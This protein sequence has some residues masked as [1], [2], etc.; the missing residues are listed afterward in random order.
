MF[1]IHSPTTCASIATN[2]LPID[3]PR[4]AADP[5]LI[6][7]YLANEP[8][9]EE[10]PDAVAALDSSHPCKRRL[11][12]MLQEKYKTMEALNRAWEM[13]LGSFAEVAA[14]GLPVKTRPAKEDMQTFTAIFLEAY[15][16]LV[17][18]ALHKYDQNHLLIGNR[19]QPGTINNQTV[20]RLSGQYMDIVSFNYYA[21]GFDSELLGRIRRWMGDRPMFFSE[22]YFSSPPDSGL[23]GGGKDL[24]SQ[25][26]QGLAYRHYVEHAAGLGY[27]VG[28]EW[29]T[30]VDQATTGR[31]FEKYNGEAANTG[32]ISVADRPWK[33]M[34]EEMLKTNYDI[35]QVFFG[36]RSPF[37]FD[38]PR[39][40]AKN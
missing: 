23:T 14:R 31:F 29:F 27:V 34:L 22:F 25:R 3:S 7:Y 5:L 9:W 19:F 6:G 1:S 28:I 21:Y 32:L 17:T 30:L 4:A 16:R 2:S 11:A 18:E 24:S 37:V 20:C 38:D 15:F 12:A 26:A 36:E 13:S 10:I 40:V 33:P 8:L 39:F 35:C